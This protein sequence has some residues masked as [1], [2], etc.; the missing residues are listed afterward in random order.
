VAPS[1]HARAVALLFGYLGSRGGGIPHDGAS[2]LGSRPQAARPLATGPRA[3]LE[4]ALTYFVAAAPKHTAD[5]EESLFPRLR[6]MTDPAAARALEL[7]DRLE[8]DHDE[9][10]QHHC[11][12]DVLGRR[13]LAQGSLDHVAA[14]ALRA[15]LNALQTIYQQH[16]GLEDRELFPAAARLLSPAQLHAVGVEMAARRSKAAG[17]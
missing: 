10:E 16:I 8:Q 15:H 5:E 11:S 17:R 9:A 12:V 1:D 14:G 4:A 13:W 6:A 7:L 3:D 2:R